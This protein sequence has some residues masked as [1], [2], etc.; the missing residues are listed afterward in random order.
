MGR[1][2][3]GPFTLSPGR[4]VLDNG[5]PN[6]DRSLGEMNNIAN[7]VVA[8]AWYAELVAAATRDGWWTGTNLS[9]ISPGATQHNA[10]VRFFMPTPPPSVIPAGKLGA[11]YLDA[12]DA[13]LDTD[14]SPA[15]RA[16]VARAA[17]C[18]RASTPRRPSSS[19]GAR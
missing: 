16:L 15:H 19:H 14:V 6:G 12:I 10:T 9:V 17:D 2:R 1:Y 11:A 4:R 5:A 8:W 18:A 13:L 7:M 3:F